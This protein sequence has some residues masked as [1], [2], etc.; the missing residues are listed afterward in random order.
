MYSK[1]RAIPL[2]VLIIV[3][4]M[5]CS[6]PDTT[7]AATA[8][9]PPSETP[10]ATTPPAITTGEVTSFTETSIPSLT[11]SL[12]TT[13]T[14]SYTPTPPYSYIQ[15]VLWHDTCDFSGGNGGEAVVLGEGCVQWARKQMN[16]DRIRFTMFTKVVGKV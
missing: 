7:P 8:S 11:P 12:T 1:R 6:L 16:L 9:I 10:L 13:A 15:G 14:A 2:L 4:M 3:F 5:A